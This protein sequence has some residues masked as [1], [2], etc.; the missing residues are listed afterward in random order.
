MPV[1]VARQN[2]VQH[3]KGAQIA[4]RWL[5]QLHDAGAWPLFATRF[6]LCRLP[7]GKPCKDMAE[8]AET[9]SGVS[10][11]VLIAPNLAPP[12]IAQQ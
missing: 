6:D 5:Q 9:L 2:D 1:L 12:P 4:E 8:Y 10:P 7:D 11:P 3:G